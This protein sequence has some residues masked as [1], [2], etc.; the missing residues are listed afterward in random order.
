MPETLDVRTR[1]DAA[2]VGLALV[3]ADGC[4]AVVGALREALRRAPE[5]AEDDGGA[6][7][8]AASPRPPPPPPPPAL[9][10]SP[11][12]RLSGS[13]ALGVFLERAS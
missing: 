9:P 13:A 11:A 8:L 4:A 7:P 12:D 1:G 5:D 10:S 3:N 2:V 6:P